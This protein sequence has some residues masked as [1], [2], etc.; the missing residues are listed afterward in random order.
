[1]FLICVIFYIMKYSPKYLDILIMAWCLVVYR[2]TVG[3]RLGNCLLSLV[4][5]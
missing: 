4:L 5:Q 2:G 1:M 3:D